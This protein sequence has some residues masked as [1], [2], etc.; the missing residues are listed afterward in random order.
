MSLTRLAPLITLLLSGL[1]QAQVNRGPLSAS[2]DSPSALASLPP[3]ASTAYPQPLAATTATAGAA[4]LSKSVDNQSDNFLVQYVQPSSELLPVNQLG[5]PLPAERYS[6]QFSSDAGRFDVGLDLYSPP[7]FESGLL[8]IGQDVAM[9]FGGYVKA[10][11]IYDFDPIDATDSFVTTAIPVGAPPR[12]NARFHARQSRF[13]FDTR[14]AA[15]D[16]TVRFFVEGDFFSDDD[17]YRLRHAYGEV[18]P[19]IVGQ[20]W[21]TFSD[22]AAAPATLDFEGSVSSITRRQ[23]QARLTRTLFVDGLTLALAVEDTSFIVETPVGL[24]GE[25]RSPS[26]DLVSHLRLNKDWG[27]FQVGGLYRIAGFQ[28]TGNSVAQFGDRV[29]TAPAWGLNFTGVVLVTN[30]TTAYYQILF[31]EGIGSYRNLPDAAPT[32]ATKVG[33]LPLYGWMV[34][35]T[36]DW[37]ESLSS[38]FTYAE[39]SLD[40]TP[41]QM[42]TDV[43]RT[44]YLAANLIWTPLPRV[45]LGVEYLYGLREN[46][47]GGI[48]SANRL[49]AAFIFNLP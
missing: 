7:E 10:D 42:A 4:Q 23:A 30:S 33:L 20:T 13:S 44:T 31:G 5:V 12:T 37:N 21:T 40:T 46:V 16:R 14:W 41:F 6:Q 22:V 9:K 45:Q 25:S 35:F 48:G 26:P 1:G 18:G 2:H 36:R 29:I 15:P 8:V 17:G 38:N 49:Q 28:P 3:A 43:Q 27:R 32:G 19:L 24:T 34:G 47:D 39:N 11:F